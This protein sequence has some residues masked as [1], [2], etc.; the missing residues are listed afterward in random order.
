[1]FLIWQLAVKFGDQSSSSEIT[2]GNM[3]QLISFN[4][5]RERERKEEILELL[6]S[7]SLTPVIFCLLGAAS[8]A[9]SIV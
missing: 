7:T 3:K 2:T 6:R 9:V 4:K 5:K 8:G 1:M